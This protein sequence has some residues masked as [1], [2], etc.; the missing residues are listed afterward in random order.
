[1]N[2][3]EKRVETIVFINLGCLIATMFMDL[4]SIKYI[5]KFSNNVYA[6]TDLIY[7]MVILRKNMEMVKQSTRGKIRWI[8]A[9]II[10]INVIFAIGSF[11]IEA[12]PMDWL[13]IGPIIVVDNIVNI[14]GSI[15]ILMILR[16]EVIKQ[17]FKLTENEYKR[18]YDD[19]LGE[20]NE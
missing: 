11:P 4:D 18:V 20:T 9:L 15:A 19:N 8:V 5:C 12:I 17:E 13:F 7:S 10:L 14:I 1:M 3:I 16:K 2:K 6:I